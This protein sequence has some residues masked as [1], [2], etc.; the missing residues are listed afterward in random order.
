MEIR[1]TCLTLGIEKPMGLV[2]MT[3]RNDVY[4]SVKVS[5]LTFM[6]SPNEAFDT[7]TSGLYPS[8][9]SV[10]T[11]VDSR[12]TAMFARNIDMQTITAQNLTSDRAEFTDLS[13]INGYFEDLYVSSN[14]HI[15]GDIL[16]SG[17]VTTPQIKFQSDISASLT[18]DTSGNPIWTS[19][20]I[21]QNLLGWQ[22][23]LSPTQV[24]PLLPLGASAADIAQTVN[25]LLLALKNKGVLIG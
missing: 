7:L 18:I 9:N 3:T 20:G 6:N 2:R 22:P 19:R 15:T 25:T 12:G 11:V 21:S 13:A 5:N 17:S 14:I 8:L 10:L 1:H 4:D 23:L 24:I 16:S